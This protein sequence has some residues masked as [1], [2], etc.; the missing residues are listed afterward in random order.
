MQI[1]P[2]SPYIIPHS[3]PTQIYHKDISTIRQLY[4]KDNKL[5]SLIYSYHTFDIKINYL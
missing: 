4:I 3:S 1:S 5:L 2:S